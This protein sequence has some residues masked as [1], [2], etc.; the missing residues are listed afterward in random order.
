V[1]ERLPAV[2]PKQLIRVLEKKGWERRRQHGSHL[3]LVHPELREAIAVPMHNRDLK[4]G[5]LLHIL[6]TAGISRS[7][8]RELL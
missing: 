1:S 6:K 4:P 3:Y 2:K 8:L 5:L 7:E